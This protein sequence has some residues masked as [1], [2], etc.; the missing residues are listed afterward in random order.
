MQRASYGR[1]ELLSWSATRRGTSTD[2]LDGLP[3][4]SES[5]RTSASALD[6]CSL[7]VHFLRVACSLV[8]SLALPSV[9]H[10]PQLIAVMQ[11]VLCLRVSSLP[12][13]PSGASSLVCGAGASTTALAAGASGRRGLSTAACRVAS[14]D[15]HGWPPSAVVCG[16]DEGGTFC[17]R[18][19]GRCL[20]KEVRLLQRQQGSCTKRQHVHP[21]FWG[22]RWWWGV[23][24]SMRRH[25]SI[26]P[27]QVATSG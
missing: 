7:R 14:A 21:I 27:A 8:D 1:L 18:L 23:L 17:A 20:T 24:C 9:H 3:M 6:C 26:L 11:A 25:T 12:G 5:S 15:C 4:L 13:C 16:R 22:E 19:W 2:F 10:F